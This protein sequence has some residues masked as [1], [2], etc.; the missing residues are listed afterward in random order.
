MWIYLVHLKKI[1]QNDQYCLTLVKIL[2]ITPNQS[3]NI[4]GKYLG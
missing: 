1:C 3:K 4:S 2:A